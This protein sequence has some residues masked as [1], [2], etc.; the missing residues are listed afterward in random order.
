MDGIVVNTKLLTVD[1]RVDK[2]VNCPQIHRAVEYL[3]QDEVVAFPTE[4]VYGLGGN[5]YS[6]KAIEK[7]FAAKGRPSDN[8]LIVHIGS[9]KQLDELVSCISS[10][11][12]K[13]IEN[14]WPG[15]L[16]LIFN[17]KGTKLSD[18]VTS[19]LQTVAVRMPD[20]P[21]AITLIKKANIPVAAPSA[22]ESGKPS[23]TQAKHVL[24]DLNGKIAAIVDGGPT[25]VGI[26]ST[27]VDCT[28]E[29]PLILRPGGISQEQLERVIG[30][31]NVD[32]ALLNN[33]VAPK[34]P[35]MKYRH[36]A[37]K[38]QLYLV[39]GDKQFLQKLINEK[40]LA[41]KR[42]GVLTTD[43]NKHYYDAHTVL[44]CG[45]RSNLDTV[46]ANLFAT[47]RTFDETNIEIIYAETFPLDGLGSAIMNRLLK[48]ASYQLIKAPTNKL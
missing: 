22:N 12:Q 8:P 41:G 15:P 5:A 21:I 3:L 42:V 4:T 36:Y 29:P 47:L 43:E 2:L 25:G 30:T 45:A 14:F 26:E 48:A 23:P 17:K 10:K 33:N 11:A 32:T 20:N 39:D 46:A 7:I 16:T 38:A 13:L 27:V 6:D 37:P 34:S 28:V 9:T 19:G 18:K 35:G 1:K 44:S 40:K 24:A 31:V